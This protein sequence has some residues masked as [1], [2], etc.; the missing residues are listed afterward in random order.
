MKPSAIKYSSH[1]INAD[2]IVH[3][4]YIT[5]DAGE[6]HP[7]T[8]AD[9]C[10]LASQEWFAAELSRT[11]NRHAHS[12]V[13][14]TNVVHQPSD[15]LIF[16]T[17]TATYT[18]SADTRSSHTLFKDVFSRGFLRQK[19]IRAFDSSLS[20]SRLII[21]NPKLDTQFQF[22]HMYN[23][24]QYADTRIIAKFWKLVAKESA[25]YLKRHRMLY[26]QSCS[27][28]TN[29][30]QLKLSTAL[31]QYSTCKFTTLNSTLALISGLSAQ[32]Q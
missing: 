1:Q 17:T 30:F 18:V 14:E 22:V 10:N 6:Q 26:I 8:F 13:L 29:Y 28:Y 21:P 7:M 3:I 32:N 2:Q 19:S 12:Y 24:M 16:I 4:I 31:E 5:P 9:F 20:N 27:R 11:L 25:R 15:P 23:F